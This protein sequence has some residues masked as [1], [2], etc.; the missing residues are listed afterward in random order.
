[1]FDDIL[2][3]IDI[4]IRPIKMPRRWFL[5]IEHNLYRLVFKPWELV[6]RHKHLLIMTKYPHTMT[7]D[8]SDL[9]R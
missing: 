5:H 3:K 9:N 6:I 7:G 4:D 2:R 1:M 8:M